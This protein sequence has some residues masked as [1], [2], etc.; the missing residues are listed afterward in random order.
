MKKQDILKGLLVCAFIATVATGCGM[1]QKTDADAEMQETGAAV[2][3]EEMQ[4][5]QQ[6][7]EDLSQTSVC[8]SEALEKAQDEISLEETAE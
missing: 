5:P 7:G 6:E 2:Q 8:P 1:Q 3:Q 4:Q